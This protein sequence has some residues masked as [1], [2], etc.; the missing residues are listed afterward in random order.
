MRNLEARRAAGWAGVAAAALFAVGNAI[1]ALDMPSPGTPAQELV[2][3]YD[4]SSTEILVGAPMSLLSIAAFVVFAAALR[5]VLV[6]AGGPEFL[7]TAGFGGALLAMAAGLGAE[8]INMG[9]ALRAREGELTEPLAQALFEV[10]QVLGSY[11]TAAGLALFALATGAAALRTGALPRWAAV[12]T[13]AVGV[14]LLT[15]LAIWNVAAGTAMIALAL[16]H[17]V[18]LLRPPRPPDPRGATP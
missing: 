4:D 15:P 1:W 3:F 5:Q 10:P 7:A 13:L 8:S 9:G 12:A 11:A 17:G 6:D 14:A 16:I 18:P 2:A